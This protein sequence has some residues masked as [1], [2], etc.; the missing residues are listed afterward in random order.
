MQ[1]PNAEPVNKPTSTRSRRDSGSPKKRRMIA[2]AL[3]MYQEIH[4][5]FAETLTGEQT[6]LYCRLLEDL[7]ETALSAGLLE[8]ARNCTRFPTIA[9]IRAHAL[10]STEAALNLE[11]DKA[12]D[13]LD[14][15]VSRWGVD[16]T[17][18]WANGRL[19]RAPDVTGAT[20]HALRAVGGWRAYASRTSEQDSYL[21]H[22]FRKAWLRYKAA[23][24]A[25][26][27]RALAESQADPA[28]IADISLAATSR[29]F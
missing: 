21:R 25:D 10:R 17:P 19:N 8:A 12:L 14:V 9:E 3:A 22:E 6:A 13:E 20:G 26:E 23:S 28:L 7:D 4:P 5:G 2:T 27:P 16:R 1:Q 11:A 15:L 29:S 24:P 18:E